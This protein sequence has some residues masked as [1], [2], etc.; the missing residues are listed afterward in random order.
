[1]SAS[2]QKSAG[3][4]VAPRR[5]VTVKDVAQR[6]SASQA[7]VC[8]VLNGAKSGN[9][10]VS[11]ATRARIV[12]AAAELGYKRNGSM[13]TARSGRFNAVGMLLSTHPGRSTLPMP[14]WEG[15]LGELAAHDLHLIVQQ[16]PDLLLCDESFVPKM[17]REWMCDG[18]LIDYTHAIPPRLLQIIHETHTPAVWLNARLPQD[19]IHPDD[20]GAGEEA[21]RRLLDLGHARVAY[22]SHLDAHPPQDVHFSV[23]DRREGLRSTLAAARVPLEML[24]PPD[25]L[26]YRERVAQW[27]QRLQT[28]DRPTAV[29]V[30]GGFDGD[31]VLHAAST[32]R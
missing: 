31:V 30:Y 2:T 23:A 9:T 22:A 11:E 3:G 17:L 28:P 20:R 8:I 27:T 1:M 32:L 10:G 29:V 21:G 6:A 12:E 13:V 18:L 15:V 7:A 19:C 16:M 5:R 25:K 14:L 4:N 24:A 26:P